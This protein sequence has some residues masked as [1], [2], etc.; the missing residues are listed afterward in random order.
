MSETVFNIGGMSC[1]HCVAA[2]KKAVDAVEGV[3][4]SEVAVGS[5]RVTYDDASTGRDAIARAIET[6]GYSIME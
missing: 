4:A 3:T 1:Q 5:A 2:V 6:A